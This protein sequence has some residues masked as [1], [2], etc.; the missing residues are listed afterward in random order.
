MRLQVLREI[1]KRLHR[2]RQLAEG[3]QR[4][5][6]RVVVAAERARE[7]VEA[8]VGASR[9][10]PEPTQRLTRLLRGGPGLA[11][12]RAERLFRRVESGVHPGER[13]LHLPGGGADRGE[14]VPQLRRLEHS[15]RRTQRLAEVVQHLLDRQLRQRLEDVLG[16]VAQLLQGR[17][18]RGKL[19]VPRAKPG[20][21]GRLAGQEVQVDVFLPGDEA[22]ALQARAHA[23]LHEGPGEL[24]GLGGPGKRGGHR[25]SFRDLDHVA[26]DLDDH[27]DLDRAGRA[28][29]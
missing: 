18:R 21:T 9:G 10:L 13:G 3:P 23:A 28:G 15:A 7:H 17:G 24:L 6:P 19:R 4:G 8:L 29:R 5:E 11:A 25:L 16:P 1:P 14:A 22:R 2:A 12:N 26:Q 27:L 20:E